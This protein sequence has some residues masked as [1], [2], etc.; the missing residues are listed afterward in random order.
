MGRIIMTKFKYKLI[1][2]YPRKLG[3][4]ATAKVIFSKINAHEKAIIDFEGIEF[5]SRNFGQGYVAQKHLSKT[6]ITEINKNEFIEKLL[7]LASE[8]YEEYFN[9]TI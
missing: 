2:R 7:K 6:K 8:E 9:V 1:D 4:G 3:V 5:I